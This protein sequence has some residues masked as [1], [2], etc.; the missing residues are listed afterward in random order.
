MKK[1][2]AFQIKSAYQDMRSSEQQVADYLLN[3]REQVATMS[4]KELAKKSEGSQLGW[5]GKRGGEEI[6]PAKCQIGW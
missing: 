3:H 1:D 4:L 5:N 6:P 2:I